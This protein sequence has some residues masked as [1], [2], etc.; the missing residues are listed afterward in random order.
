MRAPCTGLALRAAAV[1]LKSLPHTWQRLAFS[2]TRDPHI[3]QILV[4]EEGLVVVIVFFIGSGISQIL[5]GIIPA[6]LIPSFHVLSK[7]LRKSHGLCYAGSMHPYSI[8]I[9]IPF[10]RQRCGYCDFNTYA[11]QESLIPAYIDALSEEIIGLAALAGTQIPIHTVFFGG[12]TPS[13]VPIANLAKVMRVIKDH[14]NLLPNPEITLEANPGTV[15]QEYLENLIKMGFTRISY[16]MQSADAYLLCLL[17]RLHNY[18]DVI[19][20][21]KWAKLAG[22]QQINL[23]LIF[24]ICDQTMSVWQDSLNRALDLNPEHL[25]LYALT[26]EEG[27]PLF[28]KV[29]QGKVHEPDE[30][31]AADMYEWA[32]TRLD[33]AGYV[34]YE[35]SNWAKQASENHSYF[36]Q[37]NLQYW[38]NMPYLGFGAGAHGYAGGFRIANIAGIKPYIARILAGEWD[39]FPFSPA[40]D[41]RILI[42]RKAEM[43]ETMMV[44]LRLVQEGVSKG[45][46]FERFGESINS[47]FGEAIDKSIRLGLLEWAGDNADNLRLT[48]RGRLLGN[49][50]FIDFVGESESD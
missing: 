30:D 2:L 31:L 15:T 16:G 47:V 11:G 32:S 23:D 29:L 33:T 24:G 34:Q 48:R 35:I 49:R 4:G 18:N 25:S 27:T 21:V 19:D 8:Y 1:G 22:F 41:S 36:C 10:C 43:Q 9:H 46:F 38:R 50:V 6:F 14:F 13:I 17:N 44:G 37:H 12:G 42:D 39:Q 40:T 20:A 45:R 28:E 26:L 5:D 3:G 7:H